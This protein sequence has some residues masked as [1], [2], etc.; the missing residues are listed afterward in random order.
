ML[1]RFDLAKAAAV[2]KTED[3]IALCSSLLGEQRQSVWLTTTK[4]WTRWRDARLPQ[5]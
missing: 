4:S 5:L 3:R 1:W 2:L